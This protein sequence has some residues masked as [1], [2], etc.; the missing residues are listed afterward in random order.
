[1]NK[2]LLALDRLPTIDELKEFFKCNDW[3]TAK[4]D[5]PAQRT[6]EEKAEIAYTAKLMDEKFEELARKKGRNSAARYYGKDNPLIA[7]QNNTEDLVASTVVKI[8]NDDELTDAILSQFDFTDPNIDKKA[9]DFLHNAVNT[10]LDVMEYEK[11]AEIVRLNSDEQDFNDKVDNNYRLKD[12]VRR[13]EHTKDK[14]KNILTPD[15]NAELREPPKSVEEEAIGNVLVE[16]FMDTLDETDR[17]IF[18]RKL[19]GYTQSE[20]AKELGFSNN[21]AVSKR[22]ADME[23]R[24]REM[25]K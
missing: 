25:I 1:M 6:P 15:P 4:I 10:M 24:F 20:I 3:T 18:S 22:L 5:D 8:A 23:K 12:H 13:W 14:K 17:Q 21:S 16:Q 9:D 7:L 2:D 11:L 19:L